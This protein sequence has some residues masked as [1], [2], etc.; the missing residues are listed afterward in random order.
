[1][2]LIGTSGF[3]YDH[4]SDGVFYPPKLAKTKWLSFYAEHFPVI[5][6]NVT[7]Y[8]LPKAETFAGWYDRSPEKFQFVLKGSRYIT[9]I[10]RLK[11]VEESVKMFFDHA[12]GLKEKFT[13]ALWQLPPSMHLD[14]D[15]LDGFLK[16]LKKYKKVRHAFEFRHES[17]WCDEAFDLLKKYGMAFSHADYLKNPSQDIPD[18]MPF[19]YVRFHGIGA[20]KYSGD[21]PNKMLD[22]WAKKLRR[23]KKMKK[24]AYLF[25]NNDSFGFAV[26]NAKELRGML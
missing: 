1:M 5:E 19:H 3:S 15:R 9:H 24:D 21:Y 4:W 22:D 13:V 14:V 23:W 26:K 7:F 2:I 18:D 6:L 12:A 17:W 10:K 8:R 25:F 11:D 16:Q 20:E